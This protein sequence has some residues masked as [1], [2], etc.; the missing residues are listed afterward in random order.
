MGSGVSYELVCYSAFLLVALGVIRLRVRD[1]DRGDGLLSVLLVGLFFAVGWEPQGTELVWRYPGYIVYAFMDIP[2]ALLLSWSWWMVVC[3]VTATG[4]E[5]SL[6]KVTGRRGWASSKGAV[7][8]AGVLVALVIE[9]L[10]VSMGWWDYLVVGER[11]A[12]HFPLL[13]VSFNLTVI[14]GW[15]MLT[16]FNLT[17]SERARTLSIKMQRLT[18]LSQLLSLTAVCAGLGL[19]SGWFSWQLVGLFAAYVEGAA[20]RFFFTR[21]YIYV[22]EGVDAGLLIGLLVAASLGGYCLRRRMLKNDGS[23]P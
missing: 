19:F 2:L 7:F 12:I 10:S 23:L 16:T 20:P 3:R 14:V 6:S 1:K 4:I 18:G 5:R 11:A 17:L 22:L 9:P 21:H 13:D 8:L 15:G